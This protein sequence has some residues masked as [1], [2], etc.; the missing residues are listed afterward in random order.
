MN[1]LIRIRITIHNVLPNGESLNYDHVIPSVEWDQIS[2]PYGPPIEPYQHYEAMQTME[3]RKRVIDMLSAK[4][5]HAFTDAIV[6]K[7]IKDKEDLLGS[8][9]PDVHQQP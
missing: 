4:F 7:Y 6:K 1:D 8:P 9:G 3:R 5:A 2:P